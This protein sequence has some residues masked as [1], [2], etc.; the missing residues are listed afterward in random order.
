MLHPP[1]NGDGDDPEEYRWYFNRRNDE[2]GDDFQ[3]LIDLARVM[4][5]GATTDALFDQAG[6][7]V[8]AAVRGSR[9]LAAIMLDIDKFKSI[10][11]THGHGVG[12]E[13]IRAVAA[14]VGEVVR[15]SDVLGRY[16][17]EE[18]AVVLPET[19]LEGGIAVAER[20]RSLVEQ[21]PFQYENRKYQVTVSLGLA[22]TTGDATL[23]PEEL[24]KQADDKLYQAKH[25]G[26]NRVV[27]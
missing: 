27:A 20:I 4:D 14:R 1:Y 25:A 16:G 8:D 9:D 23:T 22:T 15:Q 6:A 11:D 19:T 26:R 2:D 24:I 21:Q 10:N 5:P 7:L 12:D 18:F 3:H 13:V 17:G